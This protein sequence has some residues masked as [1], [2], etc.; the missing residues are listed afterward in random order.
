[1]TKASF[2]HGGTLFGSVL[3]FDNI[4]N[5]DCSVRS[6]DKNL[7]IKTRF[8]F[9]IWLF[10]EM[11]VVSFHETVLPVALLKKLIESIT[12]WKLLPGENFLITNV[13]ISLKGN[14]IKAKPMG[15]SIHVMVFEQEIRPTASV[16]KRAS[17][18]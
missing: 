6:R 4:R 3:F 12:C 2:R 18:S 16:I 5:G 10:K 14:E 13:S 7:P 9:P 17:F 8:H 15:G 11:R 1:M